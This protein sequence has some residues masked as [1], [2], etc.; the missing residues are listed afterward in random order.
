MHFG[1]IY[2]STRKNSDHKAYNYY[3]RQAREK[4]MK[5]VD[6]EKISGIGSSDML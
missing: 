2:L 3:Y 6:S 4:C 5:L 1:P